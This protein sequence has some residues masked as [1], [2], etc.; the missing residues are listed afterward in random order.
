MSTAVYTYGSG[1]GPAMVS[2]EVVNLG[3]RPVVVGA[4]TLR[5]PDKKTI[6]L[7]GA[8]GIRDFPKELG[9]GASAII[10]SPYRDIA[11]ALASGGY[12]SPVTIT[13]ICQLSTGQTFAG[14]SWTV[15]I[16]EWLRM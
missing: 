12:P 11:Q 14:P 16:A 8:D 13:P 7:L 5:L 4:P 15:D 3:H 10:R 1:V 2:I 6:A 9:D